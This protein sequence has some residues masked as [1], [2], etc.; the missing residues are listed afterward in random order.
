MISTID[1]FGI[2]FQWEDGA[3]YM[4]LARSLSN[5][6]MSNSS[7]RCKAISLLDESLAIRFRSDNC[8]RIRVPDSPA[9]RYF[10]S[11][12]QDQYIESRYQAVEPLQESNKQRHHQE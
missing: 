11:R 3:A 10:Q 12:F 6:A 8:G 7:W 4:W 5:R 9:H 2:W 1:E